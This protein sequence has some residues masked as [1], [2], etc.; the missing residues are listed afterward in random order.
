[1]NNESTFGDVLD[2]SVN[3]SNLPPSQGPFEKVPAISSLEKVE[4]TGNEVIMAREEV[5]R[6]SREIGAIEGVSREVSEFANA[7]LVASL[8]SLEK[9]AKSVERGAGF[10]G[11]IKN[12]RLA[13]DPTK[14]DSELARTQ[15]GAAIGVI[16]ETGETGRAMSGEST[17]EHQ[18]KREMYG[19]QYEGA[20]QP[21][22][23]SLRE[24]LFNFANEKA[25]KAMA[26]HERL[27]EAITNIRA[28]IPGVMSS[29]E[30]GLETKDQGV[31]EE[32]GQKQG[33]LSGAQVGFGDA[34]KA[35][36]DANYRGYTPSPTEV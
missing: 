27:T 16:R 28:Q 2:R 15:L 18:R 35:A 32:L 36:E 29:V 8:T 17:F 31:Q 9:K 11:F 4:E 1:M 7:A 24:K 30:K 5:S 13:Q 26:K 10:W 23:L 3:T 22:Q 14:R 25:L 33:T 20:S 21:R 12:S 6:A 34:V 19:A